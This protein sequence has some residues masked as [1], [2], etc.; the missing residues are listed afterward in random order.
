MTEAEEESFKG[1]GVVLSST[2]KVT[3]GKKVA[4]KT[5]ARNNKRRDTLTRRFVGNHDDMPDTLAWT[6]RLTNS[7]SSPS[8]AVLSVCDDSHIQSGG[9]TCVCV[10]WCGVVWYYEKKR[11]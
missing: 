3:K 8:L 6:F 4:K 5:N 9:T 10:V 11:Y 2:D 1:D 7:V